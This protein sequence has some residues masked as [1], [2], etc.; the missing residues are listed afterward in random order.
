MISPSGKRV[1][2][3]LLAVTAAVV[4]VWAA[5][6]PVSF[7]TDFPIAGRGWVSALGPYNEHLIRDVGAHYL[8]LLVLSVWTLRRPTPAALAVTGGAWTA[9]NSVHFLWH[10]LHLGVFPVADRIGNMVALGAVLIASL[11][12]LTPSRKPVDTAAVPE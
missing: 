3:A 1:L 9:F 2:V 5:A 7:H 10:A 4:G 11:L 6:F 12:L 8:G